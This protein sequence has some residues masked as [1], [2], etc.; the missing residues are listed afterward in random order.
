M[1]QSTRTRVIIR[2][3]ALTI[4]FSSLGM[5]I[6]FLIEMVFKADLSK[7][8]V[9]TISFVTGALGAL[10]LFPRVLG[11][12]FGR[13]PIRE[14]ALGIGLY[15]PQQAWKHIILGLVC[16]VCT[17][18]GL[19]VGSILTG[20]YAVDPTRITL[21]QAVFALAPGVW[22]EVF[23]RGVMMVILLK[24]TGSVKNAFLIQCVIFALSHIKGASLLAF[25]DVFSVFVIALGLTYVAYKTRTLIAS[26]I[27]HYVHDALLFFVQSSD[28]SS[29]NWQQQ[30]LVFGFLWLMVGAACL[31]TKF[32]VQRFQI[33]VTDELYKVP[34]TS[35]H[36]E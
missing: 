20:E 35:L 23:F 6:S 22:E 7:I 13:K 33:R 36:Q 28:S 30:A 24:A 31:I 19:L 12:P 2:Q 32:A 25:V 11:I 34:L 27:F 8:A 26:I 9:A 4:A 3:I 5:L 18:S 10:V 17:L 21:S 16:A 1:T 29:F 14:F 15:L